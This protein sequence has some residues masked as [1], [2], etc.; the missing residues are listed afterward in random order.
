MDPTISKQSKGIDEFQ[1]PISILKSGKT[2][3]RHSKGRHG[4][5][6]RSR[7]V[8]WH[9]DDA[10]F[11]RA[12]QDAPATVQSSIV[13]AETTMD[14]LQQQR[15]SRGLSGDPSGAAIQQV[16]PVN[17]APGLVVPGTVAVPVGLAVENAPLSHFVGNADNVNADLFCGQG[18]QAAAGTASTSQLHPDDANIPAPFPLKLPPL[19]VPNQGNIATPATRQP[20]PAARAKAREDVY[21]MT[22]P[23]NPSIL[24][25]IDP[26]ALVLLIVALG[27]VILL[28]I[29]MFRFAET[30]TIQK[31]ADIEDEAQRLTDFNLRLASAQVNKRTTAHTDLFAVRV[32]NIKQGKRRG[33]AQMP[34][35]AA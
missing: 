26:T 21:T 22:A 25:E 29:I 8:Q 7:S 10:D 27:T 28:I 11:K 9:Y 17:A 34:Q 12:S 23:S 31:N 19:Y 4:K 32:A 33:S 6:W 15:Q 35:G 18:R 2:R 3:E 5:R 30:R 13:F 1:T 20:W 16:A 24:D 14:V